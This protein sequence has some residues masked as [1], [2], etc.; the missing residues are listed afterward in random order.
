M[1][2]ELDSL[3]SRRSFLAAAGLGATSILAT[4]C[5]K[6]TAEEPSD[7]GETSSDQ[8]KPSPI[9]LIGAYHPLT[10]MSDPQDFSGDATTIAT[11][12]QNLRESET[13][14]N[15]KCVFV[16]AEVTPDD[17]ENLKL[18]SESTVGGSHISGAKLIVDDT[19][20][21]LDS[22]A[23]NKKDWFEL[24][25]ELGYH[26][27]K[28]SE[29]LYAGSE[30]TYKEAFMFFVGNNDLENGQAARITW[31]DLS[32]DFEMSQIQEVATPR[33]MVARLQG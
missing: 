9:S 15:T 17:K 3:I 14:S 21:Y 8:E 25:T 7:G 1:Q 28:T 13:G 18:Q 4:G 31:G 26:N 22:Y 6:I 10:G 16:L 5:I 19:N 23:G 32:L 29:T 12:E 20:D 2:H 11:A 24:L 33:E 30:E 27:G